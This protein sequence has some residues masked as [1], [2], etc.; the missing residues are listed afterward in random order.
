M[1]LEFTK[2]YYSYSNYKEM[3]HN[4]NFKYGQICTSSVSFT[5]QNDVNTNVLA[6]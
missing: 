2:N 1:C 3:F 5:N 4:P 6:L